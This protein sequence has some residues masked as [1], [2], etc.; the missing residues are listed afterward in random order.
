MHCS[1]FLYPRFE[2][3]IP[4][5]FY[6]SSSTFCPGLTHYLGQDSDAQEMKSDSEDFVL[7]AGASLSVGAVFLRQLLV[8]LRFTTVGCVI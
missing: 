4:F 1:L 6:S 8:A 2:S 7:V 5:L 3:P